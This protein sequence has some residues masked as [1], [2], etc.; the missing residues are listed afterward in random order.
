MIRQALAL[1]Q[2]ASPTVDAPIIHDNHH[3]WKLV[4]AISKT[5]KALVN[6]SPKSIVRL[7]VRSQIR[8]SEA[9]SSPPHTPTPPH[10]QTL[11]PLH[12]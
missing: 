5:M 2:H 3:H 10:R 12:R 7:E 4:P 1:Y 9:A 6:D 11:T 8:R